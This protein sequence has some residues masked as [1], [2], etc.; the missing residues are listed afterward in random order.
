MMIGYT[1]PEIRRLLTALVVRS[2]H[3][4]ERVWAV[5]LAQK[6]PTPSPNLPLPRMRL[7]MHN[8]RDNGALT[9]TRRARPQVSSSRHLR[10]ARRDGV[11]RPVPGRVAR[12]RGNAAPVDRRGPEPHPQEM[13]IS[14]LAAQG[15]S[16]RDIAEHLFLSPRT[17]TTHLSRIYPKLG[18]RSRGEL[19]RVVGSK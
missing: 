12:V 5:L 15:L 16:N 11:G 19:A 1:V 7:P 2:T 17:A 9:W 13:Q 14:R 8:W 4:P 3:P 18:I 10:R 6:T